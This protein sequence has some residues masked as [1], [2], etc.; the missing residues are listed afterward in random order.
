MSQ[1]GRI[2]EKLHDFFGGPLQN[3]L[4][5]DRDYLS[6]TVIPNEDAILMKIGSKK[7]SLYDMIKNNPKL[8]DN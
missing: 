4:K 6:T 7:N 3:S 5:Y 2:A 1:L 8:L